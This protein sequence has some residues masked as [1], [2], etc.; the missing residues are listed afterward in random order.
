MIQEK[1]CNHKVFWDAYHNCRRSLQ[2]NESLK[3]LR[4]SLTALH[5]VSFSELHF[6]GPKLSPGPKLSGWLEVSLDK[7]SIQVSS[8]H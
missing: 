7:P 5:P 6:E 4:V 1:K 2:Q 8:E 3:I